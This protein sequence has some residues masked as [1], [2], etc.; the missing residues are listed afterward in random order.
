VPR[1]FLKPAGN[2]L[3]LQE[4]EGG[5]PLQVSLD[6]VSISQVCGHVTASHLAPVSSWI[7]HNQGYK[8][9]AKVSGRRPKVLLACPSK[10]KI[11]RIS[12]ASYGT[13]LGNCKNSMAVGTCH[14]QN[15]K[16]VVEEVSYFI[17]VFVFI[18][19]SINA[20]EF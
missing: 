18:I 19:A 9:P 13:P 14:S 17:T 20:Q 16:A 3:V 11:S 12:F 7:E 1:S 6:T 2:L 5:N 15:S 8:N 4:E 10:S